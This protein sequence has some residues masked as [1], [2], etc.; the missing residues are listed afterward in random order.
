MVYSNNP[1][2]EWF[3]QD[4]VHIHFL[5]R[6]LRDVEPADEDSDNIFFPPEPESMRAFA[7]MKF[8]ADITDTGKCSNEVT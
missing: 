3:P 8:L 6:D 2:S 7:E 1:S 4:G 5:A